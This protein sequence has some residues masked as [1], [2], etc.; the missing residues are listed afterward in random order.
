MHRVGVEVSGRGPGGGVVRLE[1]AR[2]HGPGTGS[3][4]PGAAVT[5]R[6]R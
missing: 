2:A 6:G 3:V 1:E 5:T 4:D